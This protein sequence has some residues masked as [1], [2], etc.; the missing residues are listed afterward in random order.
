MGRV[1]SLVLTRV[2]Q[3]F[4]DHA[5]DNGEGAYP[6]IR[7]VAWKCD[8]SERQARRVVRKLVDMKLLIPIA[9][10]KGGRGRATQYRVDLS[11]GT[12][13]PPYNVRSKPDTQMSPFTNAKSD[14]SDLKRMTPRKQKADTQMSPQPPIEPPVESPHTQRSVSL[15]KP[16]GYVGSKFSIEVIRRYVEYCMSKGQQIR[17]VG[18]YASALYKSGNADADIEAFL[19]PEPERVKPIVEQ[20]AARAAKQAQLTKGEDDGQSL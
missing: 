13:K 11:A 5:K 7:L 14:N 16:A 15:S 2:Q 10:E 8:L 18:A 17:S 9:Y 3:A 19:K 12:P 4:C 6:S 20:R 1:F